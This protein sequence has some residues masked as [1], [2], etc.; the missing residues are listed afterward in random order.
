VA[1]PVTGEPGKTFRSEAIGVWAMNCDAGLGSSTWPRLRSALNPRGSGAM[2]RQFLLTSKPNLPFPDWHTVRTKGAFL[3]L[4]PELPVL[5]SADGCATIIG[6]AIDPNEPIASNQQLIDRIATAARTSLD[7]VLS[8]CAGF[9]GRW[10]ILIERVEFEVMLHDACGLRQVFYSDGTLEPEFCAS[11]AS[12]AARALELEDDAESVRFLS[13]RF[14]RSREYWWPG[15]S[16]RYRGVKCL[17]PNHYLDLRTRAAIRYGLDR[18]IG[19]SSLQATAEAG[20]R[21]LANLVRAAAARFPVALPLTAGWDSRAIL[22]ACCRSGVRPHAYTLRFAGYDDSH[23]DIA[24]P[25]KLLSRLGLSH[26][27]IDCG[28]SPSGAFRTE[29]RNAVDPTDEEACAIAEGLAHRYPQECISLSGHCSEVARC[30]YYRSG[31]TQLRMDPE[32]MANITGMDATPWVLRQFERWMTDARHTIAVTGIC[33]LD[34][35]YWEQRAGRWAANGQAQWDIVHER[36]T[37]FGYRP[38]LLKLVSTDPLYRAEPYTLYRELIRAGAPE[39]LKEPVNP[40][41]TQPSRP[42]LKSILARARSVA[43]G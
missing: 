36:F 21:D 14:A 29:Y 5:R 2:K 17:L 19:R 18:P 31:E 24:M 9:G 6:F 13:T 43:Y 11:Q 1:S 40:Q 25:R 37:P 35:F 3:H 8:M 26:Q 39:L 20:M 34:L 22:A 15:D 16:T 12:T 7:A 41:T 30:Y 33:W 42:S 38:L 28:T 23:Q 27:I 32:T 4:A 10:A